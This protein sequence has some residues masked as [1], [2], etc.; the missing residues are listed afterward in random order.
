M[1][2]LLGV[3]VPE[4]ESYGISSFV[5]RERR[6]FDAGS[7]MTQSRAGIRALVIGCKSWCSLAWT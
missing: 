1:R 4:T 5:Y 2:E 7:S 3:H 6:P